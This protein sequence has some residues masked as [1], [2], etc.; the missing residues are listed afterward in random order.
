M[1]LYFAIVWTAFALVNCGGGAQENSA[2]ANGTSL[3]TTEETKPKITG[4]KIELTISS[5]DQM[6]FD[7]REMTVGEGQE[8]TVILKHIGKMSKEVMGHNW[9][10]L[11]QGTSITDYA[12]KALD[13]KEKEYLPEE[14][15]VIAATNMIGGGETTSITFQAPAKG[16]YDFICS[17]PGHYG[18]MKGKFIVQ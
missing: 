2:E 7:K 9:V 12:M 3:Q 15:P 1:K 13:A 14:I 17:Y 10:L 5:D 18:L 8:V 11:H 4:K 16:T 6:Q